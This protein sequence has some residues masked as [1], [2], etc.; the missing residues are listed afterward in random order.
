MP[1]L[2][3][4]PPDGQGVVKEIVSEVVKLFAADGFFEYKEKKREV[5]DEKRR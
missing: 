4:V 5:L 1:G 3:P 2:P